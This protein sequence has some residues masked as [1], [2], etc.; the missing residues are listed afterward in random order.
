MKS[1]ENADRCKCYWCLRRRGVNQSS[2]ATRLCQSC[3]PALKRM[4]SSF[5]DECRRTQIGLESVRLGSAGRQRAAERGR[6]GGSRWWWVIY[7]R[8]KE[9]RN[10]AQ[11]RGEEVL[12]LKNTPPREV[13]SSKTETVLKRGS[14]RSEIKPWQERTLISGGCHKQSCADGNWDWQRRTIGDQKK[15]KKGV[16]CNIWW[17]CGKQ[18]KGWL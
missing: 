13:A 14:K 5:P 18:R 12:K 17:S 16:M 10:L 3:P 9:S 1:S 4:T 6:N 8:R 2:S 15:K 11:E 7:G